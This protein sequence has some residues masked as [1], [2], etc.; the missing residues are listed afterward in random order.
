V[1]LR[2]GNVKSKKYYLGKFNACKQD[3]YYFTSLK[4]GIFKNNP[5][6]HIYTAS[7]TARDVYD[8]VCNDFNVDSGNYFKD[9]FLD[10][11]QQSRMHNFLNV[12]DLRSVS[13]YPDSVLF[14]FNQIPNV[15]IEFSNSP[16]A[17]N[18]NT[19][20]LDSFFRLT[21]PDRY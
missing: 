2:N 9:D 10:Q 4:N 15:T 6:C 14:V 7:V 3:Y 21:I 16:I 8:M 20:K 5:G 12:S 18:K 11:Q 13:Y 19:I 17:E 1:Y